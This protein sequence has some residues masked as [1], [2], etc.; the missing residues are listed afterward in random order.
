MHHAQIVAIV[1][2]WVN[3]V[4]VEFNLCP[5]AKRELVKHRV[6]FVV[7]EAAT[8]TALLDALRTEL[9]LLLTDDTIETSLLIHPDV[10]NDF[11]HYNQFLDAADT[12]LQQLNL[13]GRFQIASFHPHYQFA[14]T[15]PQAAENYSNRSPY[16]MLHVLREASIEQALA[17][18][19]DPAQIPERN[20]ALLESLGTDKMQQL[21]QSCFDVNH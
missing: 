1:Q 4:V 3:S 15:A 6:R 11:D 20:I 18:C 19:P 5:F 17:T 14:G 16:P 21:L 7:T 8:E 12:L 13:E 9:A 10:L 2:H